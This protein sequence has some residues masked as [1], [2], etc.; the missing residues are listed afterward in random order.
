MELK[1]SFVVLGTEELICIER[2]LGGSKNPKS[3]C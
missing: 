1:G 2:G 3:D